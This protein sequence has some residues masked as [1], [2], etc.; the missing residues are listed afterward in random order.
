MLAKSISNNPNNATRLF[1]ISI[2]RKVATSSFLPI[3]HKILLFS[4]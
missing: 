2:R 4:C 3:L 1:A